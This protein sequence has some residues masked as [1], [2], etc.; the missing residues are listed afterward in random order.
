MLVQFRSDEK[1]GWAIG[2]TTSLIVLPTTL[3]WR[4][5]QVTALKD[6]KSAEADYKNLERTFHKGGGFISFYDE[7]EAQNSPCELMQVRPEEI[8]MTGQAG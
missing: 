5:T 2:H 8:F 6:K 1:K 7:I 3:K 4:L